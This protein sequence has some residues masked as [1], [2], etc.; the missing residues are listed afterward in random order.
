MDLNLIVIAGRIAAEPEI[1]TFASGTR[2]LRLLVTVKSHEPRRRIDVL[3][4][5]LWDP[6]DDVLPDVPCRG[7]SVWVA[8]SLQRR[9]W[10][11]D[12]GRTSRVEVVAHDVRIRVEESS[13]ADESSNA[14]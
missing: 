9:F 8:G 6:N 5:V 2:L 12:G 1:V 4:V 13:D 7:R 10:S 3:P 11:S 14:A